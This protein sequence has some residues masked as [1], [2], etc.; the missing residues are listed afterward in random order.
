M[1]LSTHP[2]VIALTMRCDVMRC[3]LF[4]V[5]RHYL[6]IDWLEVHRLTTMTSCRTS[7]LLV[8]L[9]VYIASAAG[10][11]G[12]GP[13]SQ[14]SSLYSLFLFSVFVT[15]RL[16]CVTVR[17][18]Q[19]ATLKLQINGPLYSN[20]VIGTLVVDG[21]AVTFGTARRGLGGATAR[22]GPSSLYQM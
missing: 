7:S 20:T 15:R 12:D 18:T 10:G 17:S 5:D 3:S 13:Q 6:L 9:V 4:A 21:W 16:T 19:I 14:L 1:Q 22:P 2:A 8:V 11:L